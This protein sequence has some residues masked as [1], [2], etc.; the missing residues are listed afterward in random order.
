M[1]TWG[2][3]SEGKENGGLKGEWY[4]VRHAVAGV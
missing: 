1:G 3:V 2:G 4:R